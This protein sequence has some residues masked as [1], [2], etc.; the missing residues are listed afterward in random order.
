MLNSLVV[1][2]LFLTILSNSTEIGFLQNY[3]Q[4]ALRKKTCFRF[5]KFIESQQVLEVIFVLCIF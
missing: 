1:I 2:Y 3:R 4:E 5:A